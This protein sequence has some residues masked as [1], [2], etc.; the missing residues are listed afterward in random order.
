VSSNSFLN[1]VL[2]DPTDWTAK[3]YSTLEGGLHP[4]FTSLESTP[5]SCYRDT[6]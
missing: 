2:D 3:P 6:L 5:D 1:K 4:L